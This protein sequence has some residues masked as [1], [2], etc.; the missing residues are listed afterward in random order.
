MV[1]TSP[2][3][4]WLLYTGQSINTVGL[5]IACTCN[6]VW[7]IGQYTLKALHLLNTNNSKG[8]MYVSL[9]T[10]ICISSNIFLCCWRRYSLISLGY[11]NYFNSRILPDPGCWVYWSRYSGYWLFRPFKQELCSTFQYLLLYQSCQIIP[12]RL[13]GKHPGFC[14]A[15]SPQQQIKP[16]II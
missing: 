3:L 14:W 16:G 8:G 11:D 12:R 1:D 9:V 4:L 2:M 5:T 15:S 7:Q 10:Y 13:Q 6:K